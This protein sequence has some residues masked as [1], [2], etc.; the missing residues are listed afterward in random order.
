MRSMA[1]TFDGGTVLVDLADASRATS[2]GKAA[3][4]AALLRAGLAVPPGFV[5]PTCAYEQALADVDVVAAARQGAECARLLVEQALIRPELVD[6]IAVA[7]GRITGP[8]GDGYVAVRSSA[9]T[10]DGTEASAAGQH[11]TFLAIHGPDQVVQAVRRCWASL[12]SERSVAYRGHRSGGPADVAPT[13]AVL[14]Q[15]LVQA[16]VAGVLFTGAAARI[17]A[18]WGLGESVVSGRVNPDGWLVTDG[19]IVHRAVG[20]KLS[21]TDRVGTQLLTRP[22]PSADRNR[23]CL[24]DQDVLAIARIGQQIERLLG[25]P[26]DVEWAIADGQIWILQARPITADL[27]EPPQVSPAPAPA[28]VELTGTPASP[29]QATGPVRH[30]ES[31]DDFDRVRPGDILVCRTTDPSWTALFGVVAA[32]VTETGGLLSHAAIVAREYGLPA[33]VAAPG[34]TTALRDGALV[35]VDGTSGRVVLTTV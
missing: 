20:G 26:Q 34:A 35:T 12:W 23:P 14:V 24:R 16:D 11:N 6:E 19:A 15:R 32:V 31:P 10:E 29:G 5:V 18:S 2:G 13:T 22:V 3:P 1:R 7:L 17:E 21:R 30:V 33:V 27:P 8:A 4:L 9:N 28:G 25:R